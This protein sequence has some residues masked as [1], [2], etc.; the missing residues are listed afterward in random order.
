MSFRLKISV[1]PGVCL[2][3]VA[4][5]AS[6]WLAVLTVFPVLS[7]AALTVERQCGNLRIDNGTVCLCVTERLQIS[8]GLSGSVGSSS[9]TAAQPADPSAFHLVAGR[10]PITLFN[11][12]LD[13]V[14][15]E[16]VQDEFGPGERFVIIGQGGYAGAL[17]NE[18]SLE[19]RLELTFYERFPGAVICR[20]RF[21]NT[22]GERL[23][24]DRTVACCLRLDRR[25]VDPG[26]KPWRLASFQGGATRWGEDY[27]LV[28]LDR[29]FERSNFMG[30]GP[31]NG[32]DMIGGGVPLVDLWAPSCGLAVASAEPCQQWIS[33]PVQV[34][35]DGRVEVS[36]TQAPE[37]RFGQRS[38]LDPGDTLST[39]RCLILPH[40]LDFHDPLR[41]FAGII[42]AQGV[43]IP[44]TSAPLAYEPYWKSWG[45]GFDFTLDKI[46]SA[47]PVL[48]R[49]GVLWA[50]LDDGW[51]VHYGDLDL[52][53]APGKFPRGE[54][55][56]LAF[57][58]RVHREGFRT[59]LWWYPQ[60]VSP[61]SRLAAEHPDW[62]VANQD[63]TRPLSKRGL[64][65]L[66]P[67]YAPCRE[68]IQGWTQKILHDW[69][70]DGLY[71]DCSDQSATP[72]CFN[73]AH[74]HG[75]P[76]ESFQRQPEL[77]RVI[78]ETAQR[79]KP[80]CPVEVCIC[81][82]PHDPFKMPFYNVANTSDP[83]N[84]YQVRRRIKVE[85]AFRGGTFCVGDCYQV[86]E[87]EWEGFSV[88]ES[89][90]SALG[91]GAQVTTFFTDLDPSQERTWKQWIARYRELMLAR[92]EYLNLYDLAWDKPE[93]HAVKKGDR[94]YYGFFADQWSRSMPLSLRGL[95]TG[96]TYRVYDWARGR[97]L[98]QVRGDNPVLNVAFK[99]SLL[100]EVT[101][102]K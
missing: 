88:P 98:G 19:Q 50:N 66:C 81:S 57:T 38:V 12:S 47:L 29:E 32:R 100:L 36:I 60:G 46:Y 45:F 27:S 92:G 35:A 11:A 51:F 39:I 24:L 15:R 22:G 91:T 72:P 99:E 44:E 68:F 8:A 58:R 1:N 83:V 87:D 4:R 42:R 65:Y 71:L 23:E 21:R 84:L 96:R 5:T 78:W 49:V 95:D 14:Q 82:M 70:Y 101:P 69:D 77:Y 75:N 28:W 37:A 18:L 61:D 52:N 90:E 62:L 7:Q 74:H 67:D 25:Q 59:S 33:L 94:L 13:S 63:G 20:A 40:H 54:A 102:L 79:L 80:G 53:P 76:L 41:E 17:Y 86:P 2:R 26:E 30:A 9:L 6:L 97:E 31:L 34:L 3:R 89:F 43:A 55:D 56:M 73:P 10:I 93:A 48:R 64:Y 16:P 85:K